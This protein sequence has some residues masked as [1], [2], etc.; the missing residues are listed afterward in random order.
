[1][2][3]LLF[4]KEYF[5][6]ARQVGSVIPSS[7]F[8]VRKMLPATMPWHKMNQIAELG[9]GTGVMTGFIDSRRHDRSHFYLFEKN[10]VFQNDLQLRFPHLVMFDDALQLNEVVKATGRPFDLIVS[11]L[12]FA[13][14]PEELQE[15]LFRTIH[16][17][18]A[19]NG[20][21]IAFQYTLMLRKKFQ[22][23]FPA[24]DLGYTCLNI[25]PAWVFRWKKSNEALNEPHFASTTI[26]Q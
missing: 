18:L 16:D 20:A 12:P 23:H 1:M 22:A 6:H 19:P 8:L 11:G 15:R 17:A 7:G 21:F 9:P 26:L 14:F 5:L 13:N 25:P 24:C 3:K 10:A 2:K 4:L